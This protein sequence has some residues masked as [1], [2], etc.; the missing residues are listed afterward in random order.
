[1]RIV[2]GADDEDINR[3]GLLSPIEID[4]LE[5]ET[6]EVAREGDNIGWVCPAQRSAPKVSRD[7]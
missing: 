7:R 1:M 3:L 6:V 2:H 4:S 5:I